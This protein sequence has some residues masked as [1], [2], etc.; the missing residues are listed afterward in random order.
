MSEINVGG[1]APPWTLCQGRGFTA[2]MQRSMERPTTLVKAAE[3][4]CQ[5]EAAQ[6]DRHIRALKRDHET[7]SRAPQT[8]SLVLKMMLE[9]RKRLDN[10]MKMMRELEEQ[11]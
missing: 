4:R 8:H 1:R 2:A 3:M 5:Q 6:F 10:T 9:Q 7:A 11:G